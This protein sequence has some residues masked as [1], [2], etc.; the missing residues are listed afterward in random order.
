MATDGAITTVKFYDGTNLLSTDAIAPFTLTTNLSGGFHQLSA[1]AMDA[2]GLSRTSLVH[3]VDVAYPPSATGT[4]VNTAQNTAVEVDLLTLAGDV[5]TPANQLRFNVSSPANGTVTLLADGH[6]A[7]FTPATNYHGPANFNFTVTDKSYDGRALFHYDFQTS[8]V[9]DATGQGRDATVNVQGT[10]AAGY[11][12]DVP[13]I[14]LPQA[15]QSILLTENGTNGAARLDRALTVTELDLKNA[16]WSIAGWFKRAATTNLDAIVQLGESGGFGNS[17]MTLGYYGTS[18]TLELRNYNVAVQDVGITKA[19]VAA[20][21]WH[22]FAIVRS[23]STLSLYLDGTLAGSDSAFAFSF[24]NSK[25]VRFGGVSALT[26]SAMWDRWLKGSL[27]DLALFNT[28]LNASEVTKLNGLPTAYFTGQAATNTI[29]I[30]VFSPLETWRIEHFGS[31]SSNDSADADG[32][33]LTNAQ[34]YVL[35]T[36]PLVKNNGQMAA[37]VAS[38]ML[39]FIFNAARAEGV[40]YDG[41]TRRYTLE[42]NTD[43][44]NPLNWSPVTGYI[45]IVGNDQAV[46]VNLPTDVVRRFY[47]VKVTLGP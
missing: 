31:A 23:G 10:G 11:T 40:A 22:H 12:T 42:A 19:N 47:R 32:D 33:G 7:R 26:S 36:D 44:G 15:G 20:N 18:S 14:F 30:T 9:T 29:N 39:S 41:M 45:D 24:D 17:A 2:N 1:V 3:Q 27:A 35:G 37:T 25:T 21:V 43:L 13:T 16:D 5:E 34:E 8:D 38:G 46:Q 6:T 4:N 28:A